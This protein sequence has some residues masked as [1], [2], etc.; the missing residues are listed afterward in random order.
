M[1]ARRGAP[2]DRER[3]LRLLDLAVPQFE[4]IGMPGWIRRADE[5]RRQKLGC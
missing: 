2:G 5:L 1:Y 4:S 3:A